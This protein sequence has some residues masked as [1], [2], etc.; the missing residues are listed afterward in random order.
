M[1]AGKEMRNNQTLIKEANEER[2]RE[3]KGRRVYQFYD[4][5]IPAAKMVTLATT[6]E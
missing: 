5:N 2:K 3:K 4:N 6:L 1:A